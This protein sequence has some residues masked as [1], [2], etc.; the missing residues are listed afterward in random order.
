MLGNFLMCSPPDKPLISVPTAGGHR[1]DCILCTPLQVP[2]AMADPLASWMWTRLTEPPPTLPHAGHVLVNMDVLVR[3]PEDEKVLLSASSDSKVEPANSGDVPEDKKAG[4][5]EPLS[6]ED[7][8]HDANDAP[9][10]S[11]EDDIPVAD[12]EKDVIKAV[13]A[14]SKDRPWIWRVNLSVRENHGDAY[15]PKLVSIGPLHHGKKEALKPMEAI[16]RGYVQHLLDRS[17]KN[18]LKSYVKVIRN[19][20]DRARKQYA[21]KIGMR[22]KAFQE[23]LVVD[24]C[25]MIEYFLR[26]FFPEEK[27]I[28][29][30]DL[31]SVGWDF[32]HLRRDLMLLE[33]QIPFFVL[34]EL[35]RESVIPNNK[36]TVEEP[37]DLMTIALRVLNFHLPREKRPKADKVH[38]L[39]HL[40]YVCLKPDDLPR[41]GPLSSSQSM[42]LFPVKK[43]SSMISS[44]FYSLLYVLL[45]N[46]WPWRPREMEPKST[47]PCAT[48]LHRFGV[49]LKS[50]RFAQNDY[51]LNVTFSDGILEVPYFPVGQTTSSQL[52]NFIAFERCHT[53]GNYFT[54]Y[55]IF[56][57][58][59]IDT[60]SDVAILRN[61]GIIE[62][63]LGSDEQVATTF[64]SLLE[65]THISYKQHFKIHTLFDDVKNYCNI[66]RHMWRASLRSTHLRSPWATLSLLAGTIGI[67]TSIIQTYFSITRPHQRT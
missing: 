60:Q 2:L 42:L 10:V 13:P 16:K 3:P 4:R 18:S 24:G 22:S 43:A 28:D 32:S 11:R 62:T 7:G 58:N 50:K 57:D 26:D 47:I 56:M 35:F 25:F 39:L 46:E 53:I 1:Q 34:E 29:P 49:K 21:E 61:Y 36:G 14:V 40:Q 19:C 44:V 66:P 63:T 8:D 64:N 20:E 37:L 23:M 38:H 55:V 12:F 51:Y 45:I 5:G 9:P 30:D 27:Q 52:R 48:E 15:E 59:I 33:N 65:G 31:V 41:A 54:E 6:W 67:A 17:P